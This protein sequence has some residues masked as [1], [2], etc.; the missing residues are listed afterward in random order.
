M[1]LKIFIDQEIGFISRYGIIQVMESIG[2]SYKLYDL[3]NINKINSREPYII[4]SSKKNNNLIKKL[5][6]SFIFFSF[7]RNE[8]HLKDNIKRIKNLNYIKSFFIKT[9]VSSGFKK[10]FVSMDLPSIVGL[11]LTGEIENNYKSSLLREPFINSINKLIESLIV[12]IYSS[13]NLPLITK[14]FWPN[15]YNGAFVLTHDIDY[16]DFPLPY[17]FSLIKKSLIQRKNPKKWLMAVLTN[18]KR[19][20]I[21]KNKGLFNTFNNLKKYIELEKKFNAKSSFYFLCDKSAYRLDCFTKQM[22]K[23]QKEGWEICL[24]SNPKK[25]NLNFIKKEKKKLEHLL[26]MEV[27]SVRQHRLNANFPEIWDL[28]NQAGFSHDSSFA[29]SEIIGSRAG[30]FLPYCAANPKEKKILNI[31]E[32]PLNIMD[33]TLFHTKYMNL[34]SKKAFNHSKALIDKILKYNGT[35][36]LLWHNQTLD[37]AD[38]QTFTYVYKSLL[39]Y[40]H[41][42]NIWLVN[43][44]KIS[45][46]WKT[47][48]RIK[49]IFRKEKNEIIIH[50]TSPLIIKGFTMKV[51]LFIDG[52]I[53]DN[54][55]EYDLIKGR[56]QIRLKY[57]LFLK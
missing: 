37:E 2:L 26:G 49:L 9:K 16:V 1:E 7:E 57:Q 23:L 31:I 41:K 30:F 52:K 33:T 29:Y 54:L 8:I 36:V 27:Y 48:S 10:I 56:N 47:R 34:D 50:I 22:K 14:Y 39:E 18:F 6:Y 21:I 17:L 38:K 35:C 13:Y 24:H 11:F 45:E 12:E 5:N 20:L 44:K 46:W 51:S 55:I 42:K 15:S 3:K 53:N 25:S 28:Y 32:L 4:Y 40:A 43:S 19:R